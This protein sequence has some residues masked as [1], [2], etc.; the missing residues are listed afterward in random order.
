MRAVLLLCL[1]AAARA[2]EA[3]KAEK[4]DGECSGALGMEAGRI[5]D[6]AITASSSYEAKSVGPQNARIR[7]EMNGGAWCPKAQISSEVREYLEV[8]LRDA[9]LITRTETQ[10][11]FGNGQG[12]EYAEYFMLEYWRPGINRWVPYRDHSGDKVLP[13]NTNTYIVARQ[14][15]AL[16]FVATKVRF[17][18]HSEHPRTVCMRVELY[19]CLWKGVLRYVASPA[20]IPDRSYDGGLGQLVDGLRGPDDYRNHEEDALQG[21][22]VGWRNDSLRGRPVEITFHFG[23]PR[24][25]VA[26]RLHLNDRQSHSAQVPRLIRVLL[27]PDGVRFQNPSAGVQVVPPTPEEEHGLHDDLH[28]DLDEEVAQEVSIPLGG[29]PARSVRV[30]LF[31]AA[32]WILLSEVTFDSVPFTGNFTDDMVE[33]TRTPEVISSGGASGNSVVGGGAAGSSPGDLHQG[34]GQPASSNANDV[35]SAG[36]EIPASHNEVLS[37]HKDEVPT[38]T[39]TSEQGRATYIGVVSGVLSVLAVSLGCVVLLLVRRGRQKV[40]L[41][42]KHAALMCSAKAPALGQAVSMKDLKSTVSILSNGSVV[43]GG[44]GSLPGNG[45]VGGG[46]S[47]YGTGA[48]MGLGRARLSKNGYVTAPRLSMAKNNV[49]YGQVV[50]GEESDSENSMAY[51]EPYK[52]LMP[53]SKQHQQEYGCLLGKELTPSK[54][55]DYAEFAIRDDAK[56]APSSVYHLSLGNGLN[57]L[58]SRSQYDVK[59][60]FGAST[61]RSSENFYA[62]TDIV[63]A[64]RREQHLAMGRFTCLMLPNGLPVLEGSASLLEFQRHRLRVTQSLGEG[65]FGSLHVCETEAALDFNGTS[66]FSKRQPVLAKTL[67]RGADPETQQEFLREA[68][69]LASIRDA[70]VCRVLAVCSQDGPLCVL[71][72]Y[73]ESQELARLVRDNANI[74]YGCLIYMATQ[75][76]SGMKYLEALEITHRDLAARNCIVGRNYQVK[77]SD[78]A[79]FTAEYDSEYYSSDTGSKLPVRWMAWEALLLGQHSPRSDVWSFAVTLWEVLGRC[80][81]LPFCELTAEQ[82]VENCSHWYQDSGLQRALSRPPLCPRE[83]YDLMLECWRRNKDTRPRFHEIHLFL[84]R[85]N[86]GYE[87]G[88]ECG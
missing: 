51:H 57:G 61:T 60:L 31:F 55:T 50:A 29:R 83:I 24:E 30:Q 54:S 6:T 74:S 41:L 2:E 52:L 70:N 48:G 64:E 67:H 62:A 28:D 84:Q 20:D 63:K 15:L 75:I 13:A 72:E 56:Y 58:G 34:A 27:S 79:V 40:S 86:L 33:M 37:A 44:V 39:A 81:E 18:P 66:S 46:G 73:S 11:R 53:P 7:Q 59:A 82:V 3:D 19:G 65:A 35:K 47:L 4:E 43:G 32:T 9:H 87:P 88:Y 49:M 5:P 10:G 21:R 77:V 85:K 36:K 16:P 8:D 71:Q 68:S 80:R 38:S 26:I 12:Q 14:D 69:W 45:M 42:H 17:L 78:H 22:W 1:L 25:F 23:M 76:A